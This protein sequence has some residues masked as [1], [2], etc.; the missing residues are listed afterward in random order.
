M[1]RLSLV[2]MMLFASP[3]RAIFYDGNDMHELC[4]N[5]GV[6][7][8]DFCM[9]YSAAVSDV[10]E[11]YPI[12][13]WTACVPRT[14]RLSQIRDIVARWLANNPQERHYTANSLMA[15]ALAEAFP[16]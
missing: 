13:G 2:M 3:A 1:L 8:S 12:N 7:G 10:L 16:C 5:G 11:D 4:N 9:A 6:S 15:R 14:V